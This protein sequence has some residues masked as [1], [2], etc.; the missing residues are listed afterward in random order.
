M[1]EELQNLVLATLEDPLKCKALYILRLNLYFNNL[2]G[3]DDAPALFFATLMVKHE[4]DW[5]ATLDSV[6]LSYKAPHQMAF[7]QKT[8]YHLANANQMAHGM[9]LLS[10]IIRGYE[11]PDEDETLSLPYPLTPDL[12]E[13]LIDIIVNPIPIQKAVD[14]NKI[15]PPWID[16]V[17]KSIIFLISK[18]GYAKV[19]GM[20]DED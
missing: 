11:G 10:I 19:C 1:Q 4:I 8:L 20:G 14:D 3:N 16:D 7:V 5:V 17:A 18:P 12:Q 13:K 6:K 9:E 2:S 15:W